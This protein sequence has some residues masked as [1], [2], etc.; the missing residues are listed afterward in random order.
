MDITTKSVAKK[1]E[2]VTRQIAG[3]TIVVPVRSHVGDL[4]A[5]YTLNEVA[6]TIWHLIDGR[7]SVGAIVEAIC[8][9]Y[10]VSTEDATRD[11][12]ALLGWLEEAGL[13]CSS[14]EGVN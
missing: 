12:V 11:V 2:C 14:P 4:E 10:D 9:D 8:R 3:E 7:T 5:I 6:T 13:T 1:T